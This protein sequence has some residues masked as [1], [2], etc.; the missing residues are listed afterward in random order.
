M[1]NNSSRLKE[2]IFIVLFLEFWMEKPLANFVNKGAVISKDVSPEKLFQLNRMFGRM[3]AAAIIP[4]SYARKD[5][6]S[7][8]IR[9]LLTIDRL[10]KGR[11]SCLIDV[12]PV[13][14]VN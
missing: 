9:G 2:L 10:E 5:F 13:V 14:T 12:K 7:D 8:V 1:K 11:I 4:E 3:G 6:Y